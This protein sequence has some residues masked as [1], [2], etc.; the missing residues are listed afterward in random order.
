M[1]GD[2]QDLLAPTVLTP[3]TMQLLLAAIGLLMI[4]WLNHP[5]DRKIACAIADCGG[6]SAVV[7]VLALVV[8]PPLEVLAVEID[9]LSIVYVVLGAA[10]YGGKFSLP[11]ARDVTIPRRPR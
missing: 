2:I 9:R 10:I 3:E 4:S 6:V 8:D 5:T 1:E 7:L 11:P